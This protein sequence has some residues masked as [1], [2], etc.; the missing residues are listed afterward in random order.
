[1]AACLRT[2]GIL[3]GAPLPR[4]SSRNA[5]ARYHK[6]RYPRRRRIEIMF[7]RHKDWRRVA[8]RY[9][10]CP[11]AFFSA[12]ASQHRHFLAVINQRVRSIRLH[13]VAHPS[14]A[15]RSSP[16]DLTESSRYSPPAQALACPI[17]VVH[18]MR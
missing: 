18:R 14:Q 13:E 9:D 5:P 7:G 15:R 3:L 8:T 1:M 10:C 11:V 2:A 17:R 12:I 4:R 6:R 16:R